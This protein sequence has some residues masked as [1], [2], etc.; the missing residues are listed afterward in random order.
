MVILGAIK[1]HYFISFIF[2]SSST[3]RQPLGRCSRKN[4]FCNCANTNQKN[5][6]RSS[7]FI[8][9]TGFKSA[10]LLNLNSFIGIFIDPE[11][12]CICILC[13]LAILKNTYS[14]IFAECLQWL[15]L[16]ITSILLIGSIKS[17]KEL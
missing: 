3:H 5:L 11:H 13:R 7:V 12:R 14:N 9:V 15:L 1:T 6:P 16:N 10:T 17:F 4:C 8:K 2:L